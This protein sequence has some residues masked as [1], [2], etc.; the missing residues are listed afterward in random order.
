MSKSTDRTKL[1]ECLE[2][3]YEMTADVEGHYPV[4][5]VRVRVLLEEVL[6]CMPPSSIV[7]DEDEMVELTA[8]PPCEQ[9]DIDG[10][11]RSIFLHRKT[12]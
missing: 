1:L 4:G 10:R 7:P 9:R 12:R 11:L 8:E 3:V 2:T 6:A 5:L